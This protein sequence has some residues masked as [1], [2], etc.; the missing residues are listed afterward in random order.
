VIAGDA[1]VGE[2]D[3]REDTVMDMS[4]NRTAFSPESR[5][6]QWSQAA[7]SD[8][9]SNVPE[10]VDSG[11]VLESPDQT[12]NMSE[13]R[14]SRIIAEEAKFREMGW[15]TLR[16][17]LRRFADEGDVQMCSMLSVVAPGELRVD[18]RRIARFLE[19][20]IG[21]YSRSRLSKFAVNPTCQIS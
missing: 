4:G 7:S 10:E 15:E 12:G 1:P 17:A 19:S 16:I 20:Y 5:K 13:Q 11:K 21:K 8:V 14:K 2:P 18:K 6:R 3:S 9:V